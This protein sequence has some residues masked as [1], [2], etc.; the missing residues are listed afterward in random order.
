MQVLLWSDDD[1]ASWRE[2]SKKE[3][4]LP[5]HIFCFSSLIL[6]VLASQKV[7]V[8]R[9]KNGHTHTEKIAVVDQ[10]RRQEKQIWHN[11]DTN[12]K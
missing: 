5:H 10:V 11:T 2:I 7:K 3:V 4:Q 9:L 1:V 6:C 12:T 8:T